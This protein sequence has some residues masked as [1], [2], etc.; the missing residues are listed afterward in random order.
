MKKIY[1][2]LTYTGTVLSKIIKSYTKNEFSHV[3]ISL[4]KELNRMYSFGR[5]KPKNPFIG[6]FVH[7]GINHG[8]FK[9]FKKTKS[10]IYSLVITDE[11]YKKIEEIINQINENKEMYKF[12]IIGLFAVAIHKKITFKKSFYCAE[13]VKYILDQA[14]IDLSLPDMIKPEDFKYIDSMRLVYKGKLKEYN[15]EKRSYIKHVIENCN[16]KQCSI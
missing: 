12:N 4:D 10:A 15:N 7:E 11:Q 3:S 14:K 6:G 13:F 2:I 16:K 5:L 9:R 1:I 8:T